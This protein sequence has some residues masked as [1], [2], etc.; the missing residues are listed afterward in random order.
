MT[1]KY[2]L[3]VCYEISQQRKIAGQETLTECL[4]KRV[5]LHNMTNL[6]SKSK[7]K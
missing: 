1:D 6:V 5:L 4:R 3:S 7:T 2:L